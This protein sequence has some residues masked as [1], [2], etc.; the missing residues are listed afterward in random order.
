MTN[1]A[2]PHLANLVTMTGL[3]IGLAGLAHREPLLLILSLPYDLLDGFVARY[4]RTAD[5]FGA[6]LDRLTD[7]ALCDVALAM[8]VG[9]QWVALAVPVQATATACGWKFSGRAAVFI[10]LAALWLAHPLPAAR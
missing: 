3:T 10:A 1:P 2:R 4:L 6:H 8:Y 9:P 5:A 7:I